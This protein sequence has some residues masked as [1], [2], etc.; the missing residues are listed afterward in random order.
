MGCND[1]SAKIAYLFV[2]SLFCLIILFYSSGY[3]TEEKFEKFRRQGRGGF[4]GAYSEIHKCEWREC[5]KKHSGGFVTVLLEKAAKAVSTDGN[6][7][8]IFSSR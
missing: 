8:Q 2:L 6:R 3:V 5:L 1:L 7:S 4:A